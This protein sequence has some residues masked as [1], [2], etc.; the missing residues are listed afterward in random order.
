MHGVTLV[1]VQGRGG[2]AQPEFTPLM[3]LLRLLVPRTCI[4]GSS[5]SRKR[6]APKNACLL[7]PMDSHLVW[8]PG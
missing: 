7:A 4:R 8:A 5:A 3:R 1:N 6:S 2:S